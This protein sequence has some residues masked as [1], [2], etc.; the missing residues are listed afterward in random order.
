MAT[1]RGP[2]P[3]MQANVARSL[4]RLM[5]VAGC[6]NRN[7]AVDKSRAMPM[8]GAIQ[9]SNTEDVRRLAE[10]KTGLE[11]REPG[12]QATPIIVASGSDQW[13]VVEILVDHGA[14]IWAH[15]Q[16]GITMAQRALT[17]RILPGSAEDHARRRVIEKLMARGYPFPPLGRD[18]VLTLDKAGKWPPPGVTR[19]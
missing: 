2:P 16:F 5:F 6:S 10:S 11:E 1:A 4:I 18:E 8:L 19:P 12:S 15:D 3:L 13:P 7:D 14:D 17:S 9:H